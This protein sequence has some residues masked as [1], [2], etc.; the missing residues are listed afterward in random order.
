MTIDEFKSLTKGIRERWPSWQ[1]TATEVKDLQNVFMS[2]GYTE[3]ED[4]VFTVRTRYSS[5]VP[6]LPWF[7]NAI[8]DIDDKRKDQKGHESHMEECE[9]ID[10]EEYLLD[11]RVK[12]GHKQMLEYLSQVTPQTLSNAV[13]T[14]I[15]RQYIPAGDYSDTNEWSRFSV[16]MVYAYLTR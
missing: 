7:V 16:G 4:A 1:A 6:K 10:L 3:A 8:K 15:S 5:D 13:S 9:R 12:A 14:C 2:V 11:Q